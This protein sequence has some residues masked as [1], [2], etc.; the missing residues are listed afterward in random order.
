MR[1]FTGFAR[2]ESICYA[3]ILGL[4]RVQGGDVRLPLCSFPQIEGP[5]IVWYFRGIPHGAALAAFTTVFA[6]TAR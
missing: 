1:G 3:L 5:D 2:R 4:S 6:Y